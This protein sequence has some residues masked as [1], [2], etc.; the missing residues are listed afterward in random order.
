MSWMLDLTALEGATCS[1]K[2]LNL[3]G[4]TSEPESPNDCEAP[5]G[6]RPVGPVPG[7][8]SCAAF[9]PARRLAPSSSVRSVG[10]ARRLPN[11][12]PPHVPRQTHR[13]R[14]SDSNTRK[15]DLA[16]RTSETRGQPRSA[17]AVTIV[18]RTGSLRCVGRRSY[19]PTGRAR[20]P[21]ASSSL[22]KGRSWAIVRRPEYPN[23]A[24]RRRPA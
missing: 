3:A 10:A 6:F 18:R 7:R 12:H 24:D 15:L 22:R 4:D 13:W 11:E 17:R 23:R 16:S 19:G 9:P 2:R 20:E 8:A 14:T 21:E 5:R 1:V